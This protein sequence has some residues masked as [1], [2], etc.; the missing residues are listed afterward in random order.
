MLLQ[1]CL[2]HRLPSHNLLVLDDKG[3]IIRCI[4]GAVGLRIVQTHLPIEVGTELEEEAL[5]KE[6][7]E[8]AKVKHQEQEEDAYGDPVLS[9]LPTLLVSEGN[10]C[11]EPEAKRDENE[12]ALVYPV[13]GLELR[14][15]WTVV[16]LG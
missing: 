5:G 7:E 2:F 10:H 12:H 1:L 14:F 3:A 11:D 9:R 16:V 4:D 6:V 8:H 15:C 13:L